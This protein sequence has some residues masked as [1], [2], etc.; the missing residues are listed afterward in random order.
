MVPSTFILLFFTCFKL[1]STHAF[2]TPPLSWPYHPSPLA[3]RLEASS[4][5]ASS[6]SSI[7]YNNVILYDGVCNFC[8]AWV[9]ILLR[10]DRKNK[11]RFA[12][13]QSRVGMELLEGV[14]KE[15]D[16]ISSVMLIKENQTGT[17]TGYQKS[18]CIVEVI[19]ELG[20]PATGVVASGLSRAL[21]RGVKDGMYD[22][23]ARNRYNFLG[24]R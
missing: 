14:G 16:D 7:S 15:K 3:S 18:D 12:A 20:I 4:S 9:D 17:L 23:V 10:V 22:A 5:P 1:I 11:F 19:K 6:S 13:L 8:N 24:K 2:L 21:P